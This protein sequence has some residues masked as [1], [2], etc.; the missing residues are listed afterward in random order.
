M[1]ASKHPIVGDTLYGADPTL[2][3]KLGID[4]QWLHAMELRFAHP[5]KNAEVHVTSSYPQD[6]QESLK[7]LTG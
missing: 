7:R 5:V 6:L 3:L 2:A 1:A 4:R